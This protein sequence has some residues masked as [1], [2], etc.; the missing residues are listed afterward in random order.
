MLKKVFSRASRR[1]LRILL[2]AAA[3]LIVVMALFAWRE[4]CLTAKCG[5]KLL[6]A[7]PIR[8]GETF[9]VTYTHSVNLSPISD[10]IEWNGHDLVVIKSLFKTFGAGVPIPGD[11]AGTELARVG[12]H[13]ELTGIDRHM[14]GFS[15][16]LQEVPNHRISLDS[17]EA[18]LL[19]LAGSGSSVDI[20]VERVSLFARL[21]SNA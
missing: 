18:W 12:D 11:E 20:A 1:N 4:E 17:R 5:G 9:E 8:A 2:P 3:L 10:V 6:F 13:Y 14:Q 21:I 15:I 19:E 16:M 7:W